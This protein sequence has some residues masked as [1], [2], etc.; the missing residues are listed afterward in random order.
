MQNEHMHTHKCN[1]DN[2]NDA[3]YMKLILARII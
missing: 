2:G 1:K 3:N